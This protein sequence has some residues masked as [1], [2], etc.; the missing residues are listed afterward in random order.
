MGHTSKSMGDRGAKS[1]LNCG[2]LFTQDVSEEKN[3]SMLP[4]DCSCDILMKKVAAF[5]PCQGNMPE[6]KEKNFGLIP[7]AEEISKQPII[8][9]HVVTGVHAYK[10]L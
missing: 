7:L 4:R 8:D 5:Y 10:D 3:L 6:G 1:D 9:C 2:G